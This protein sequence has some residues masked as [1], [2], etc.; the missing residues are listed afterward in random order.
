MVTTALTRAAAPACFGT[1]PS[2]IKSGQ[3]SAQAATMTTVPGTAMVKM[4]AT[5]TAAVVKAALKAG[6]A[7][8]AATAEVVAAA[9]RAI[10]LARM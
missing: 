8:T 6:A 2:K 5:E 10:V 3:I 1:A 7:E 4:T 9:A